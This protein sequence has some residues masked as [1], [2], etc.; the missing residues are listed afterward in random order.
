MYSHIKK[1]LRIPYHRI[2]LSNSGG[3]S[4][5]KITKAE[6]KRKL[7]IVSYVYKIKEIN[8]NYKSNYTEILIKKDTKQC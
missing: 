2:Y 6:L 1:I 7:T 3:M 5:S 8:T 4:Y